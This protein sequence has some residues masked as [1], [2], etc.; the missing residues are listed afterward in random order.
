MVV[1]GIW[2]LRCRSRTQARANRGIPSC[3]GAAFERKKSNV[4]DFVLL[5]LEHVDGPG[6]MAKRPRLSA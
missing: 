6:M 3:D 5:A 4:E 1:M 2:A